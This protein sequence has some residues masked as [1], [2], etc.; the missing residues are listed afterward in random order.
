MKAAV[1]IAA[2]GKGKRFGSAKPKQFLKLKNKEVFLWSIEA[3]ASMKVFEEI[4]AAVPDFML[5]E[6]SKKYKN[7]PKLKFA[8][9]GKERFDSIKKAARLIGQDIDF[10]AVHDGARPLIDKRDILKVLKTAV[11]TGA[12]IAVEKTKDTIKEIKNGI[13]VKTLD[14]NK[15]VNVQTPQIF[16]KDLF[17]KAYSGKIPKNTTD[18][19]FLF[20]RLNIKV[21]ATET[22][23]PNFKI[24]SKQDFKLADVL[25]D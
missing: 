17:F 10:I 24:T 19:S 12:A 21:S 11:K 13:V 22:E 4:I 5:L 9:G 14:R 16:R 8:A 18:D 6:L 2:A 20:E 7:I 1:I 23:F 15:L 25:I 3:F